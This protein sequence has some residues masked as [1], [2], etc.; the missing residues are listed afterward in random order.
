[1][2]GCAFAFACVSVLEAAAFAAAAAGG[3]AAAAVADF[4]VVGLL[5]LRVPGR[6]EGEARDVEEE[7]DDAAAAA[8]LEAGER[9]LGVGLVFCLLFALPLLLPRGEDRRMRGLSGLV[10]VLTILQLCVCVCVCVFVCH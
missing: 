10:G 7:D 8:A 5:W 1:M 4:L 3:A 9:G 2:F 6:E